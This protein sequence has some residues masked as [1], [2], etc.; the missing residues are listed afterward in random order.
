MKEVLALNGLT[1]YQKEDKYYCTLP[2]K[3]KTELYKAIMESKDRLS[4]NI[5]V[6]LARD[7]KNKGG[8]IRLFKRTYTIGSSKEPHVRLY[9]ATSDIDRTLLILVKKFKLWGYTGKPVVL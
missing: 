5:Y 2:N 4:F 1:L 7:I 9:V 6:S 8:I 3:F